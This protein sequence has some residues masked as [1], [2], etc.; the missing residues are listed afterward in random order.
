MLAFKLYGGPLQGFD[1]VMPLVPREQYR[2]LAAA[3]N[4]ILDTLKGPVYASDIQRALEQMGVEISYAE[5]ITLLEI[6]AKDK[7]I[8]VL[9]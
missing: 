3:V 6:M 2:A 7:R 1:L 8:K 9:E 4:R 5:L